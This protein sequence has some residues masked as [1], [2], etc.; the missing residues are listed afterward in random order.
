[1]GS[2]EHQRQSSEELL[3]REREHSRSQVQM[4]ESKLR[5]LQEQMLLKMREV[6]IAR[7]AQVSLKAEIESY[8]VLLEE[9]ENR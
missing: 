3:N 8:R 2:L 7:D 6:N 9:E 4:L 5:E 1:M